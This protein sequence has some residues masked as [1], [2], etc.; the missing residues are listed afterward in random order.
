MRLELL[1]C[2]SAASASRACQL[3]GPLVAA[4]VGGLSGFAATFLAALFA[5]L[6]RAASR[7]E[8]VTTAWPGGGRDGAGGAAE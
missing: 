8:P 3:G 7:P 5:G 2:G 1:A 6:W 4:A